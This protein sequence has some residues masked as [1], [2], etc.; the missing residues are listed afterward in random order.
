VPQA[1]DSREITSVAPGTVVALLSGMKSVLLSAIGKA[2][3][4]ASIGG[5]AVACFACS[6]KSTAGTTQGNSLDAAAG[7]GNSGAV[8]SAE[9]GLG[10]ALT[11][12]VGTY[13]GCTA[14]TV[15]MSGNSE[16]TGGGDGAVTLSADGD[17]TLS[18][19]LSFEPFL[20]GPVAFAPTSSVTAGLTNGPFTLETT[21]LQG[22]NAVTVS[23]GALALV[24]DTFFISLY[25][26]NDETKLSAYVT[27]PVSTSLPTATI[28]NPAPAAG[29]IP[30]G[31]YA[32]C[33]SSF[34]AESLSRTAGG[35]FSLAVAETNGLLT[36]TLNA[37]FPAVCDLAFHAASGATAPLNDAQTCTVS[38]PCG[39]PPSLGTSSAPSE[40][41]LTNM[42]GS[43]EVAGGALFIN[44]AGDASA[45]ACGRQLLSMICPTA[46]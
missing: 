28:V 40:T 8:T 22:L 7:A 20:S 4:T 44:V 10:V 24:G 43:I 39:P 27:C 3:R 42:A 1:R 41:T 34:G 46:P 36:T 23:A 35:N 25:A 11:I 15:S 17:G 32:G 21:D 31:T 26:K 37:G 12:P 38:D 33:T 13:T 9:A 29:S 19:V 18:G 45:D 30:T 16:G 6:G 14:V 2:L 5:L